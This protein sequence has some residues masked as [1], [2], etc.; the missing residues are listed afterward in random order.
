MEHGA[1]LV[2]APA[3]PIDHDGKIAFGTYRGVTGPVDWFAGKSRPGPRRRW[4][5][6]HYVSVAGPQAVL[7]VAVVDL[8]WTGS[9]F[10]YLFDR[11][12]RS[13][14]ADLSVVVPP[15]RRV[16]VSPEPAGRARTLCTSRKLFVRLTRSESGWRLEARSPA[17]TVDATLHESPSVPTLCA[18]AP[19]P[20][21]VVDCTHKTPMLRVE[22]LATSGALSFDLDG[23]SGA[24]DHSTGLLGHDT[25]WHWASGSSSELALNLTEGFTAPAE[26]ALWSHDTLELLPPVKFSFDR[27]DASS[28]WRIA[29]ESGAVELVFTPEGRRTKR[30]NLVV[31]MSDY[32][33]PIGTFDGQ[34]NGV[35]IAGLPGVTEDHSSRW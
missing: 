32:V 19:V 34:V 18:V 23:Y 35:R 29:D 20:G 15:G 1:G 31:A 5:R 25:R 17:L 28:P 2:A 11:R 16:E 21:G 27:A 9:A 33:Q 22:G 12:S 7:A 10:A 8:G 14:L 26:N 4:K 3:S 13:L 6:W 30:T 24:I